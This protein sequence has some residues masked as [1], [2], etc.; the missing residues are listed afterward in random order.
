MGAREVKLT[1]LIADELGSKINYT[2]IC[3]KEPLT[4]PAWICLKAGTEPLFKGKSFS[5]P[6]AINRS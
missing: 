4:P 2:L 5:L 6:G 3:G 1:H